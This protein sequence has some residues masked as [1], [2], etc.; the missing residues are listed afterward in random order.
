MSLLLA[1]CGK[2]KKLEEAASLVAEEQYREAYNIYLDLQDK[3][4]QDSVLDEVYDAAKTAMDD[5]DYDLAADILE[6]FSNFSEFE[7]LADKIS[8]YQLGTYITEIELDGNDLSFVVA[9]A[10][11]YEN[12]SVRI[13]IEANNEKV[14]GWLSKRMQPEDLPEG[15]PCQIDINMNDIDWYPSYCEF[16]FYDNSIFSFTTQTAL[17]TFQGKMI[18]FYKAIRNDGTEGLQIGLSLMS[19]SFHDTADTFSGGRVIIDLY[20]PDADNT[21]SADVKY[22][23]E[24]SISIP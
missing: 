4:M 13:R 9:R 2:N 7:E 1:G 11:E 12:Y 19:L 17:Q 22:A 24:E 18:N 20:D 6:P 16:S 23:A 8:M 3:E 14:E 15:N 10:E 21:E 5:G